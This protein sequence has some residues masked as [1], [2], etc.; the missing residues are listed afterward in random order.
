MNQISWLDRLQPA[1]DEAQR[2]K[3]PLLLDFWTPT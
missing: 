3:K 2:A 1:R